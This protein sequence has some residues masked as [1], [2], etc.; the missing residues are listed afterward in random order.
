MI[1]R[2][3]TIQGIYSYKNK[4]TIDFN[5]LT[6]SHLFG[7]FGVVGSGKSTILEAISFA[8]Y[9]EIERLNIKDNRN[10]NL[11]NL[12]SDTLFIE[13]IFYSD[14]KDCEYRFIVKGKRNIKDFEKVEKYERSS[15]KKV[16]QE[17]IPVNDEDAENIIGLSYEN[18]RRAIIIPQGKFNEF[19]NLGNTERTQMLK[20]IFHL[21][22]Y[23]LSGKTK[24]LEIKNEKEIQTLNGMLIQ[25]KD[26]SPEIIIEKEEELK[27]LKDHETLLTAQLSEKESLYNDLN[28][29]KNLFNKFEEN[30]R[31]FEELSLKANEY[32]IKEENLNRYEICKNNFKDILL[33][34]NSREK[35]IKN[36]E[37]ELED[38]AKILKQFE[39]DL[40]I[41]NNAFEK[42]KEDYY[43]K[44]KIIFKSQ[45]LNK[46]ID[47]KKIENEIPGISEKYNFLTGNIKEHE[48]QLADFKN[49]KQKL[50][51]EINSFKK[52]LPDA[53]ILP[54]IK[55]W[56]EQKKEKEYS[57]I[58][59]TENFNKEINDK[60]LLKTGILSKIS[61]RDDNFNELID[62]LNDEKNKI[63]EQSLQLKTQ[64]NELQLSQ[65]LY[66]F[67][68]DLKDGEPCPLCG[69]K[70]HPDPLKIE[71]VKDKIE[72]NKREIKESDEKIEMIDRLIILM[73]KLNEDEESLRKHISIFNWDNY[74]LADEEKVN[75]EFDDFKNINNK[76][77]EL[78]NSLEEIDKNIE[79]LQNQKENIN[80]ELTDINIRLATLKDREKSYLKDLK[81]ITYDEYK[82]YSI[83][84]VS[85][86]INEADRIIKE[87]EFEYNKSSNSIK[88]LEDE[89]AKI[90]GIIIKTEE[91]IIDYKEQLRE[92]IK[93][94]N[95][96]LKK[97]KFKDLNEIHEI[98]NKNMDIVREKN[99]IE[100]FKKALHTAEENYK[101]N[102]NEIQDKKYNDKYH[103]AI[104]EELLLLKTD[105]DNNNQKIGGLKNLIKSM[106]SDFKKKKKI[107]KELSKLNERADNIAILKNLFRG[108]GFVNYISSIYL[109]NLCN[110]ANERFYKLTRQN[111][112]L[113]VR[114]DNS[115]QIRDFLNNGQT[116]SVKTLSGGQSFQ[117]SLSL[118]LSL[119]ENISINAGSTQNFF[120][121][122][123]GFGSLDRE[124]LQLVFDTLKSLRKENR[125]VG[126]ISHL[127]ELKQEIDIY[128]EV[129]NDPEEGSKI[130]SNFF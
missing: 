96:R 127:E 82:N 54:E 75:K 4:A 98:L 60:F 10:Y 32:S 109:K 14:V 61:E 97:Y 130:K 101:K 84:E 105:K 118:A 23:E 11:M 40:N 116:R 29:L 66:N 52:N 63:Q 129:E 13:F 28:L 56:F 108:S 57:L 126:V 115:F 53:S 76:I 49:Q 15:Y 33:N 72:N 124:A 102:E 120:F 111:L 9:G 65:K 45:E 93:E 123:E 37:K 51:K 6:N 71:D 1:P 12:S 43:N 73:E 68:H 19:L 104:E 16:N 5:N 83:S 89:K 30:K 35:S 59:T 128:L 125:I 69:S 119:A 24:Y 55:L 90:Q 7:I 62:I 58:K 26:I 38:K 81:V 77:N 110:S 50:L 22:K 64:F 94:I 42:I 107:E 122:D 70:E 31:I 74:S 25:I 41:E 112:K 92:D 106:K 46:I 87:I 27:K 100:N 91:N 113:E 88:K 79:N 99:D 95:K 67:T 85:I 78:N 114:D 21:E 34:K 117:V 20:E 8:L 103:K 36:Y 86:Q 47:I 48:E 2:S 39:K 18:F 80:K 121:I 3:L 44:E 17:W